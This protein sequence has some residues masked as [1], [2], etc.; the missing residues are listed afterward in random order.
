[1]VVVGRRRWRGKSTAV[2]LVAAVVGRLFGPNS[3]QGEREEHRKR[4]RRG[5]GVVVGG[6]EVSGEARRQWSGG[7]RR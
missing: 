6:G 2:G 1:M 4:K 5:D 3:K 7:R